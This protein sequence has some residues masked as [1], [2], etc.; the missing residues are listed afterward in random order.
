MLLVKNVLRQIGSR[1]GRIP[2]EVTALKDEC[3][4]DRRVKESGCGEAGFLSTNVVVQDRLLR[5]FLAFLANNSA[6]GVAL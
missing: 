5:A 1:P 4:F 3:L 2:L 6:K